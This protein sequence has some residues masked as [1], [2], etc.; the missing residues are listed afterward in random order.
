MEWK[1]PVISGIFALFGGIF[2]VL[3]TVFFEGKAEQKRQFEVERSR[4]L[5]DYHRVYESKF[6]GGQWL[7]AYAGRQKFLTY[8]SPELIGNLGPLYRKGLDCHNNPTDECIRA[9][10][11][12]I[13]LLRVE[14]GNDPVSEDDLVAILQIKEL[15]ARI[16]DDAR[17]GG[18]KLR[19][20][21][22]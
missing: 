15:W 4:S 11:V 16:R 17:R 12:E 6:P 14:A 8:A 1:T 19:R 5:A 7:L 13:N 2:G 3:G 10:A 20:Q 22:K 9:A 21:P 18:V